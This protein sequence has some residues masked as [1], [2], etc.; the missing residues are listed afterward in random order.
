MPKLATRLAAIVF[1]G[2]ALAFGQQQINLTA[3]ATSA[4]LPDGS[5]VPMWGYSC[6]PVVTMSTATC[7]ALNPS[8][9]VGWSPVI[10]TVPSGQDLQVSLTNNLPSPVPTS[11]VIV[12]QLGGGLGDP[13]K[14]TTTKSPLHDNQ[15][16]TWPIANS[17][18][19]FIPP[20]QSDRVQ[21]FATEVKTGVTTVLTWTAPRPGTYL[22]ESG[23]HASIQGPMGLYGILVVTCAPGAASG[24]CSSPGFAYS[25]VNYS[26]EIPLIMSEID[27]AQNAAVAKAVSTAGFSESATYG[28]YTGGPVSSINLINPGSGYTS[29]PMVS[30]TGGGGSGATATAVIDTDS[31]SP[32]YKQITAINI[33]GNGGTYTTAPKVTISGGGGTGATATA[34][35]QLN[36]NA[37]SYCSGGAAACYPPVVNYT[38]LYYLFNGVAFNKTNALASVF[39]AT[40][41]GSSTTP[42]TGNVL[43]R[44]VNAGLRMHVPSIVGSQTTPL[45]MTTTTPPTVP[46]FSLIAEDGNPLPGVSRV[47]NE[48]FMAAGKTYDVMINAPATGASA[49]PVFDRELSL[50]ANASTRDAG[51]LAYIGVNGG[52]LPTSGAF[53]TT[54]AVAG[55][56]YDSVLPCSTDPCQPLTVS[57][58]G[59][60]LLSK[61]TNLYGV[62]LTGSGT[63]SKGTLTLNTD[64]TFAYVPIATWTASATAC[65]TSDTF[66]Y[67][68]TNG[69]ATASL[70]LCSA[71]IEAGGGITV[72]NDSYT[73]NVATALTIGTPGVLANDKDT[74]GY[75]LKVAK[76][77]VVAGSGLTV[78]VDDYGGFTAT[79]SG[80]GTYTFAYAAMNSQGTS[81][82]SSVCSADPTQPPVA[83]CAI[84]TLTFPTANGPKVQ[85]VDGGT[86][87]NLPSTLDYRWVVEEDRTFYVDPTK[88]TN[89]GTPGSTNVLTFGTNFHTSYMPL[90]AQGCTG[91]NSISC[92]ANQTVL[93][94]Q[95]L[96]QTAVDPSQLYLDIT[97]RYYI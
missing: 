45:G 35:L 36:P 9:G 81:S 75:P 91:M 50:S 39:P 80:A 10:I 57:D 94:Q 61:G 74:A 26:A 54:A 97:K 85:L 41:A 30:F 55:A 47:Q 32:T 42:V 21:S 20:T 3:G 65:T 69:P 71:P 92:G 22:I 59:K 56:E 62:K 67:Q 76:G 53:S 83:G 33:I 49:L 87:Q 16:T 58:P 23:T 70:K 44:L 13:T 8:A 46:G 37:I 17:G 7:A 27:P 52:T 11:L 48:V 72:V 77:S 82:A 73:S 89:T 43:V 5:S 4:S 18:S 79:V 29:A 78:S 84:V 60:G 31:T 68:A 63:S 88:T 1:L 90:V 66:T 96:V 19:V 51:M 24:T 6:G 14:R 38:P 86:K 95:A 15:G 40:P 93:G 2:A 28:P 12:G 25:G 34:A 64:G